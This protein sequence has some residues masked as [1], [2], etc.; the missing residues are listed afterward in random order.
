MVS[1]PNLA[2][3]STVVGSVCLAVGNGDAEAKMA[4]LD[5]STRN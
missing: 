5:N 1:P 2:R 3:Q 4:R